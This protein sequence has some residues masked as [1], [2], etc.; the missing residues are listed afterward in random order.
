LRDD[1][2]VQLEV[3]E[4]KI[5]VVVGLP[6]AHYVITPNVRARETDERAWQDHLISILSRAFRAECALGT[7]PALH[8][9]GEIETAGVNQYALPIVHAAAEM[10]VA[11]PPTAKAP[12]SATAQSSQIDH[13]GILCKH[14]G[15]GG[16]D[17][18]S[19]PMPDF[20]RGLLGA[21]L[22]LHAG[23]R[24]SGIGGAAV[25]GVVWGPWGMLGLM[26][27]LTKGHLTG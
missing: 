26:L 7:M 21:V 27:G 5:D 8:E 12:Q 15:G 23:V 6:G 25:G 2:V 1:G 16:A 17:R 10:N 3:C 19:H 20:H 22:R 4:V 24:L 11:H 13:A 18:S 14:V 9:Q